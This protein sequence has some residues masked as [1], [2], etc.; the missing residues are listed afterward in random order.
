MHLSTYIGT[1]IH[2]TEQRSITFIH[3]AVFTQ[4][5]VSVPGVLHINAL[6]HV[7][8]WPDEFSAAFAKAVVKVAAVAATVCG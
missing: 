6:E 7:S 3:L 8:S 2:L 1:R 4:A 5:L